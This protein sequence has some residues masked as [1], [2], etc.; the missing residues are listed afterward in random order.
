MANPTLGYKLARQGTNL[1]LKNFRYP[2]KKLDSSEDY[3]KIE[4][5]EYIPP[6]VNISPSSFFQP[7]SDDQNYP[8]SG[9]SNIRGTIILPIPENLPTNGNS[10]DWGESTMGPLQTAG[11]GVAKEAIT[12]GFGSGIEALKEA[13]KSGVSALGTGRGQKMA[14]SFFAT[15]AVEQ[16]LGQDND[17]F[18]T[19]LGR[20]TG[21]VFNENVEL[22][23]RGINLREAFTFTFNISPRFKEEA[24]QVKQIIIF[25]KREMSA[26][27]GTTSGA[28]AGLFLTAPS[29]F[30]VQYMSGGKPH[31]YLNRFKIC[32]MPSLSVNFTG[33]N[34]YATYSDGTPVHM[35][36]SLTFQELTPI[37]D[38]DYDN[39]VGTGY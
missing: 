18:R 15:K 17:L 37:Y 6:D 25:L 10:V 26:K 21:A 9:S 35:Q 38:R 3:L 27:K 39:V 32:A 7:S 34:T 31:P 28:A 23:F 8:S 5:L 19:V 12:G 29:V 20:T 11:I 16:L 33:S 22:L 36:L 1:A 2:Y 13:V 30:R 14:Q 24:E 4:C